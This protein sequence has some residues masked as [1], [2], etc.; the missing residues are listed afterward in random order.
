M[1]D[2]TKLDWFSLTQ[3]KSYTIF[4]PNFKTSS[5]REIFEATEKERKDALF[6][7]YIPVNN[8]SVMSGHLLG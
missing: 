2:K 7:V 4:A 6:E 3:I 1:N 8:F 5:S